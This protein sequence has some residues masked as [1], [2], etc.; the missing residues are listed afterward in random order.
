MADKRVFDSADMAR[1]GKIGG[2]SKAAKYSPDALVAPLRRG[3]MKRFEPKEQG[4]SPE[5]RQ[6]R[7]Q[8]GL[9]AHMAKLARLSAIKRA[10]RG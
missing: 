5:E 3:F 2:L 10:A 1:R 8:M 6:R 7:V 9:N 4:L